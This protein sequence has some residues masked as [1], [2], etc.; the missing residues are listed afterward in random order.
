VINPDRRSCRLVV[1]RGLK[2]EIDR[3]HHAKVDH[4]VAVALEDDADDVLAM[5]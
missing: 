3:D 2:D 1:G 5:S 4:V